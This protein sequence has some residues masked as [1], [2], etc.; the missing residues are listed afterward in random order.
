MTGMLT[1]YDP[2]VGWGT[3]QI[4]KSNN[5]SIPFYSPPKVAIDSLGNAV[6]VWLMYESLNN[7]IWSNR[8]S[9]NSAW[10]IEKQISAPEASHRQGLDM[11]MDDVVLIGPFGIRAVVKVSQLI[12]DAFLTA[13]MAIYGNT[14]R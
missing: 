2:S 3:A 6:V 14:E 9:V 7:Q 8:Y 1:I 11:A 13:D 5:L 10:G 4:I 12:G